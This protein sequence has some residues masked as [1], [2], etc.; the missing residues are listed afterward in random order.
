M[1]SV[2]SLEFNCTSLKFVCFFGSFFLIK[3]I[4][5]KIRNYFQTVGR[6][7]RKKELVLLLLLLLMV[8]VMVFSLFPTVL[9]EGGRDH[10]FYLAATTSIA[11]NKLSKSGAFDVFTTT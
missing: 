10:L 11:A 6:E 9:T 2:L 5:K 1:Y 7:E 8:V 4:E 3:K